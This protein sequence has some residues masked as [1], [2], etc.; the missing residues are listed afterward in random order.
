[1]P[2][3]SEATGQLHPLLFA[4]G[5]RRI[6]PARQVVA[7]GFRH[8]LLNHLWVRIFT[9]WRASHGDDRFHRPVGME[10]RTLQHHRPAAGE[11][12]RR[13]VFQRTSFYMTFAAVWG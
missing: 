12:F 13:P 11:R 9:P 4:A 10:L 3:L 7:T 8:H 2:Q 5:K 6:A 1:M